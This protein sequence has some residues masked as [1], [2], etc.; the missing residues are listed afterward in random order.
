[1]IYTPKPTFGGL[2][3]LSNIHRDSADFQSMGHIALLY[4]SALI[5]VIFGYF[6]V[7]KDARLDPI[8]ALRHE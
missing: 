5:G 2:L 6:P 7:R 3:R 8:V 1:L 4:F